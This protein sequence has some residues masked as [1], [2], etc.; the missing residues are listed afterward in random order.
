MSAAYAWP[1]RPTRTSKQVSCTV[2]VSVRLIIYR[3]PRTTIFKGYSYIA[4][5][6]FC[7]VFFFQNAQDRHWSFMYS[8]TFYYF[9]IL[10]CS[11]HRAKT[12]RYTQTFESLQNRLK[13][14]CSDLKCTFVSGNEQIHIPRGVF[15]FY[16]WNNT[17]RPRS[18]AVVGFQDGPDRHIV[19]WRGVL[20]IMIIIIMTI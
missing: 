1:V 9:P 20:I 11:D 6:L 14:N 5:P 8:S 3:S 16:F 13:T 2:S 18:L 19:Q 15:N 4:K 17:R 10:P 7:W 12:N